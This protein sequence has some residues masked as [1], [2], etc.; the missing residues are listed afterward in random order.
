MVGL[1]ADRIKLKQ[2]WVRSR[3]SFAE[4]NAKFVAKIILEMYWDSFYSTP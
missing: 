4:E 3:V 1:K 2:F